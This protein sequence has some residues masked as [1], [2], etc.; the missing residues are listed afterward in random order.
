M[1]ESGEDYM[2]AILML[3]RANGAAREVDVA[4]K[5]GVAR[6]SVS[7]AMGLLRQQGLIQIAE[8]GFIYFTEAGGKK[9]EDIYKRHQNLTRFLMLTSGASEE[10]AE[11]NAC[12]ME[13]II[14][15]DVY[16]GILKFMDKAL[17]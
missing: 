17:T 12:R 9:A 11:E 7:R 6:S 3:Q 1:R 13:H 8:T 2:E 14:D 16:E 10:R 5:L 15:E 4:N